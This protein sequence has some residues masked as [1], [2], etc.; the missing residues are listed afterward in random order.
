MRTLDRFVAHDGAFARVTGRAPRLAKVIDCPAHEG[1]VYGVDDDVL[2]ATSL[3]T[4]EPAASILRLALHGDRFPL[5][6]E[7][8]AVVIAGVTMPNGMTA[9]GSQPILERAFGASR[10]LGDMAA[11]DDTFSSFREGLT[12]T[13]LS[14]IF[15]AG[16]QL[17]W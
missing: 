3:S 15:W 7:R 13:G 12:T 14:K 2:Y 9:P 6:P 8:A 5:E 10:P 4:P 16:G 17:A 11:L 1:P